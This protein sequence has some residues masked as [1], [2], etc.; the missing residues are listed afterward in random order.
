MVRFCPSDKGKPKAGQHHL[1]KTYRSGSHNTP[2]IPT[3]VIALRESHPESP[4]SVSYA[5]ALSNMVS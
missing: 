1:W 2:R 5:L 4:K 3:E